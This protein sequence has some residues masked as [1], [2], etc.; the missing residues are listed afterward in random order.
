MAVRA[1]TVTQVAGRLGV[2][3][4]TVRK[5]CARGLFP[6]AYMHETPLGALWMI[7]ERDL[8][9]FQPPRMGRPPKAKAEEP[10]A[11]KRGRKAA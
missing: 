9:E 6:R 3:A 7:P 4:I 10:P 1:L 2:A 8:K 11:K 5:W